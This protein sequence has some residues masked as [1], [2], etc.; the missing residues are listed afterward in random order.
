MKVAELFEESEREVETLL[1]SM[2]LKLD[3]AGEPMK[4]LLTGITKQI[5]D[6]NGTKRNVPVP[7]KEWDITKVHIY[8]GSFGSYVRVHNE[9][10]ENWFELRPEDDRVLTIKKKGNYWLLTSRDGKGVS[11]VT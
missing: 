7:D 8:K 10:P 11:M 1:G 9:S 3:R 2:L 4:V 6:M 5:K